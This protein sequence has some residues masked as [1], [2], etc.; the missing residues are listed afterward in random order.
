M[1]TEAQ[2]NILN[3]YTGF[4]RPYAWNHYVSLTVARRVSIPRA[5]DF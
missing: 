5:E 1:Y 2:F 3:G 4:A